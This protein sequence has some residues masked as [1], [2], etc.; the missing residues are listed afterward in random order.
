M[1]TLLSVIIICA[2]PLLGVTA[3][4]TSID[5]SMRAGSSVSGWLS[6][7]WP[8]T[9][10]ITVSGTGAW[11]ISRGGTLSTACVT[12]NGYCFNILTAPPALWNTNVAGALPT[13]SDA[14]TLYLSW[15]FLGPEDLAVGDYTGTVTI[16]ATTIPITLHILTPNPYYTFSYKPGP[17]PVNCANTN[18][19]YPQADTCT[20]TDQRPNSTSFAI[21]AS[22][23]SYT[24]PQFGYT[25]NRVTSSGHTTAYSS[26]YALN[27][28]SS[29]LLEFTLSGTP[30]LINP[31]TGVVVHGPLTTLVND[32]WNFNY[33]SW[34]SNPDVMYYIVGGVIKKYVVS[35]DTISTLANY[36]SSSGMRPAL[37]NL[38]TG[39]TGRSTSDNFW[40][41]S[42][43]AVYVCMVDL[44]GLTTG[45]QESH[46][47]CW[48]GT[49]F[50]YSMINWLLTSVAST[51]TGDRYVVVAGYDSTNLNTL[52]AFD[53]SSLTFSRYIP[54]VPVGDHS[55]VGANSAGKPI[56]IWPFQSQGPS[57][58]LASMQLDKGALM[59][60]AAEDSGGLTLMAPTGTI[61]G[62]VGCTDTGKCVIS[63]AASSGYSPTYW[64]PAK[65]IQSVTNTN[66]CQINATSHGFTNGDSIQIGGAAGVTVINGAW[67][68]TVLNG[69]AFTIPVDCTAGTYTAS[70]GTAATMETAMVAT[71]GGPELAYI[72]IPALG[73]AGTIKRLATH[74]SVAFECGAMDTLCP[75]THSYYDTARPSVSPD[76]SW[77]AYNSNMGVPEQVSVYTIYVSDPNPLSGTFVRG[78]GKLA[79]PAVIR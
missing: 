13:G 26:V 3:S 71:P 48:D 16:G 42:Q 38:T 8:I 33:Y 20:I 39:G 68:A 46:I 53:G 7:V 32:G 50:S 45:N 52:L 14:T 78:P 12:Q 27:A 62:H 76:G 69:N 47:W 1:K 41:L 67:V 75:G 66:P 28:D 5:V 35:T 25:V 17:Y 57:L 79:G 65:I 29:L 54:Y 4:P 40:A 49:S 56:F 18:A 6:T 9:T 31:S 73:S 55:E 22:G 34:S 70:T 21:P 63:G 77:I 64:W 30:Y 36:T 44:N 10:T 72:E 2:L 23:A 43:D 61:F 37:P 24:D 58:M 59:G 15:Q 11:N 19:G 74:R 51:D 60:V